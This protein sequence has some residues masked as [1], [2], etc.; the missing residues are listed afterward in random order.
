MTGE[1]AARPHGWAAR[2]VLVTGGAGFL[3]SALVRR[4]VEADARVTVVDAMLDGMGGNL[5]NLDGVLERVSFVRADVRDAARM[6]PLV[7]QAQVIFNLAG[8]ISH[9]DSMENPQQDLEINCDSQLSIL[10]AC[11]RD[12]PQVRIVYAA[13]RQ[14]Y[15]R[16]HYLPI[17]ERHPLDPID[18]NGINKIAGEAY[19][20]LYGKVYG[21]R[22]TS[23]RLTNC[24]GPGQR[25]RDSRQG[26]VGWFL[27]LALEGKPIDLFGDGV[28]RRDFTHA[29]DVAEAFLLA[30]SGDAAVGEA[31]NV[32]G[33]RPYTLREF[34]E[35]L[36]E[37][38]GSAAGVR[39]VPFP[40]ERKRIDIGDAYLAS[41]KIR[42]RLGWTPRVG[43]REGLAR[44]VAYYRAHAARYL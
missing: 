20:L 4:L 42:A 19:H 27:R 41:D 6:R 15:G 11:R 17:D 40:P 35:A 7:A 3:G 43:L 28:Q 14:Q 34:A 44:T 31:F 12:N 26:F 1:S 5:F 33:D 36:Q 8:Q 25:I 22:A 39:G 2:R 32:G 29:D 13:T 24:Y 18:V 10:E 21:L 37:A 30:A 9:L 23:L 16:P 38:A